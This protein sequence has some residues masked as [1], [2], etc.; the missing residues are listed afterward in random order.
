M[1]NLFKKMTLNNFIILLSFII[2]PAQYSS[3]QDSMQTFWKEE[4]INRNIKLSN[5][6]YCYIDRENKLQGYNIT[7]NFPIASLSKIITSLAS[8]RHF[9]NAYQQF[10][11]TVYYSEKLNALHLESNGD[12]TLNDEKLWI[13][14]SKIN[15]WNAKKINQVSFNSN[16]FF[17][18]HLLRIPHYEHQWIEGDTLKV[19]PYIPYPSETSKFL[20]LYLNVNAY[21]AQI[22]KHLDLAS[23]KNSEI[24]KNLSFNY[25]E[26]IHSNEN[27]LLKADDLQI[28][29]FQSQPLL[30]IIKYI[31]SVSNNPMTDILYYSIGGE[32]SVADSLRGILPADDL[33]KMEWYTG[34]GLPLTFMSPNTTTRKLNL[35]TCKGML[36]IKDHFRHLV[37]ALSLNGGFNLPRP[38]ELFSAGLLKSLPVSGQEGTISSYT[39]F[40]NVFVGKTGTLKDAKMLST[41][42]SAKSGIRL[43][44]MMGMAPSRYLS[45]LSDTYKLMLNQAIKAF[46]GASPFNYTPTNSTSENFV[47][48]FPEELMQEIKIL[49]SV[50]EKLL[51]LVNSNSCEENN[52]LGI[53][54]TLLKSQNKLLEKINL[55]DSLLLHAIVAN[56]EFIV[57]EL[58]RT[59][60]DPNIRVY[61]TKIPLFF[62]SV[63]QNLSMVKTLLQS[64]KTNI[65]L[66]SDK[67]ETLLE[68]A[69]KYAYSDSIKEYLKLP[70]L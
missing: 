53:I 50:N 29:E 18:P 10:K 40:T 64:K 7:K 31:N 8:L 43:L 61:N 12:P 67:D 38:S 46:R 59:G 60:F 48:K 41:F 69:I 14:L 16:F 9:G 62:L 33:K 57:R 32:T 39:D 58:L 51:Y 54:R 2:V 45:R 42:I 15:Q 36:F 30:H 47:S 65:N 28:F 44:T 56:K 5:T 21:D 49:P 13:I 19:G 55:D 1:Y 52:C 26:L 27:P 3:A 35:L 70:N 11:T 22:R 63:H 24:D 66:K 25:S 17:M 6:S 20:S 37:D 34:S 4:I 68:Y 23:E